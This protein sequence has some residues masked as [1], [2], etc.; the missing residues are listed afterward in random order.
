MRMEAEAAG[1]TEVAVTAQSEAE[2]KAEVSKQATSQSAAGIEK[3]L[4]YRAHLGAEQWRVRW[5]GY[6][7]E[8]DTWER[9]DVLDTD[10][11]RNQAKE[12]MG[13]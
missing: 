2:T 10:D 8:D 11:L 12:L 4:E 9:F 7:P 13:K 3:L 1:P 6:G 5:A